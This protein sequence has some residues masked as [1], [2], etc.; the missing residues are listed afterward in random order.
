[1]RQY[2][3]VEK[4]GDI[5]IINDNIVQKSSA[6]DVQVNT[7]ASKNSHQSAEKSHGVSTSIFKS[8]H[9]KF[10]TPRTKLLKKVLL[11]IYTKT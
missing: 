4:G 6:E 7:E 8:K 5:Y 2:H 11:V 10:T 3:H 1:M 9:G